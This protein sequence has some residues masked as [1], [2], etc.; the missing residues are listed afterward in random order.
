[1][2]N[3]FKSYLITKGYSEF[4]P[5]GK[6]STAYDYSNSRLPKICKREGITIQELL[7]NIEYYIEKYDTYGNESEF[8][9]KSNRAFINA[10]KRYQEFIIE[11][12]LSKGLEEEEAENKLRFKKKIREIKD[13]I[14]DISLV[15]EIYYII[16]GEYF[17]TFSA[18]GIGDIEMKNTEDESF[19]TEIYNIL[20]SEFSER[21]LIF[22]MFGSDCE[23]HRVLNIPPFDED[24]EPGNGILQLLTDIN[25]YDAIEFFKKMK[26]INFSDYIKLK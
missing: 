6:P 11:T 16:D 18:W 21:D 7:D 19:L 26:T 5:S 3:E 10:L 4:T 9:A 22:N 1:M 2:I 12:T 24:V 25:I 23:F 14:I 8:G 17:N 13:V 15:G 20:N